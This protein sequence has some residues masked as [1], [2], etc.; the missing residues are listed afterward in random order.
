MT[1]PVCK[2]VTPEAASDEDGDTCYS[3]DSFAPTMNRST[4]TFQYKDPKYKPICGRS[5]ELLPEHY[6]EKVM[7]WLNK[8]EQGTQNAVIAEY[9]DWAS[10]E[11]ESNWSWR[12]VGQIR[13]AIPD[14]L[15]I[16]LA[17]FDGKV[18]K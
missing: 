5:P 17:V 9:E 18:A 6:V 4:Q 1:D 13:A 14:M 2:T 7:A 3:C 8:Q 11:S 12:I 16:A 10:G 15:G